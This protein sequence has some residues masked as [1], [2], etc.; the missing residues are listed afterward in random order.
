MKGRLENQGNYDILVGFH[1]ANIWTLPN[2]V[3]HA[4][5][6]YTHACLLFQKPRKLNVSLFFVTSSV[7]LLQLS[8]ICDVRDDKKHSRQF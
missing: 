1:I 3:A 6:F 5:N 7:A 2:L 4:I 8:V